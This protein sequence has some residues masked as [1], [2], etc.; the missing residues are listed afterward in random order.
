MIEETYPMSQFVGWESDYPISKIMLYLSVARGGWDDK[1][2]H[3]VSELV[4]LQN[5]D[6]KGFTLFGNVD[7]TS[8]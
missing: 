5:L 4:K 6:H 8:L 3:F 2:N 7:I 1:Y